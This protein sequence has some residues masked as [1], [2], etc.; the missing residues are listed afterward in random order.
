MIP[1]VIYT[2][3]FVQNIHPDISVRVPI[4]M[5][6][7]A[8]C[9]LENTVHLRNPLLEPRDIMVNPSS[10]TVLETPHLPRVSPDN[11][12]VAVAEKRRI[13]VDEVNAVRIHAF[14]DFEV[15]AEDEFI[16]RHTISIS[17]NDF[18]Q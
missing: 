18:A 15:V 11:L 10:P 14:E 1:E 16:Y 3:D 8:P 9:G 17:N 13:K 6:K 5:Q 4:A 2:K 12:V 7:Y